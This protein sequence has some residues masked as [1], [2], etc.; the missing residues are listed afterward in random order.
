[1]FDKTSKFL[2]LSKLNTRKCKTVSTG[3]MRK[4]SLTV[5]VTNVWNS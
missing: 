5:R 1:M 3:G 4:Y 2:Y